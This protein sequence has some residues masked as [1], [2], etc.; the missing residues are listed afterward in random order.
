LG[1]DVFNKELRRACTEVAS[2]TKSLLDIS[3]TD[4]SY[5]SNEIEKNES[6][7]REKLG[8]LSQNHFQQRERIRKLAHL[9]GKLVLQ[10]GTASLKTPSDHSAASS[11]SALTSKSAKSYWSESKRKEQ[12]LLQPIVDHVPTKTMKAR[13]AGRNEDDDD[14]EDQVLTED[15]ENVEIVDNLDDV[16]KFAAANDVH[17]SP[18]GKIVRLSSARV[19]GEADASKVNE[20]VGGIQNQPAPSDDKAAKSSGRPQ[21]RNSILVRPEAAMA[22]AVLAETASAPADMDI[23]ALI[24]DDYE[25]EPIKISDWEERIYKN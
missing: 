17:I 8:T 21:R 2:S 5:D 22:I 25:F 14:D 11:V 18:R 19:V 10:E 1:E 16:F 24:P 9:V 6:K 7:I 23:P 13:Q 4:S 20:K 3:S 15:D 12:E